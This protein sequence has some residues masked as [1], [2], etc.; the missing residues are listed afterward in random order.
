MAEH[1]IF[2]HSLM[3]WN[4]IFPLHCFLKITL[5]VAVIPNCS[6]LAAVGQKMASTHGVSATLFN[7]LAKVKSFI[8][9]YI[10]I[11][12]YVCIEMSS[13]DAQR[14]YTFNIMSSYLFIF[15]IFF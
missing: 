14:L 8:Y 6:I 10:Y 4:H 1:I 13:L 5:Q 3:Y 7:A 15:A 12:M 9:I 2:F 11:Y